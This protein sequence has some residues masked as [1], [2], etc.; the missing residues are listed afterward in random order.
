MDQLNTNLLSLCS[1]FDV[2]MD[3]ISSEP[4]H[5]EI[6]VSHATFL[7]RQK[8]T[9]IN[10]KTDNRTRSANS[11]CSFVFFCYSFTCMMNRT[12]KSNEFPIKKAQKSVELHVADFLCCKFF[13][14]NQSM[15]HVKM[16]SIGC[17]AFF[18]RL[19][20]EWQRILRTSIFNRLT[21]FYW[22]RFFI[23]F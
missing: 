19:N 20:E 17:F 2:N 1:K 16:T 5:A 23:H 13:L 10:Y 14:S 22:K 8:C 11:S 18:Y 7:K 12:K 3:P 4:E 6:I 9:S 21:G 15:N